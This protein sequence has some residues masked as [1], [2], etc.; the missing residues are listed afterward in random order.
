MDRLEHQAE[1]LKDILY[2]VVN[3]IPYAVWLKDTND[4]YILINKEYENF[5]GIK[6][7]DIVNKDVMSTLVEKGLTFDGTVDSLA[8][9]DKSVLKDKKVIE[10]EILMNVRNESRYVRIT[11]MPVC[12]KNGEVVALLGVSRDVTQQKLEEEK[13]QKRAVEEIQLAKEIQLSSLPQV[14]PPFPDQAVF[15]IYATMKPAKQV[16][17]DFY[18]FFYVNKDTVAFTVADVSDKGIPAALF[19]M[20]TKAILQS[21]AQ[22]TQ[23]IENIMTNVNNQICANN[24]KWFFVTVGL[25]II[26]LKTGELT[27][28]NAGHTQPIIKTK[29]G[30]KYITPPTNIALG[31][32]EGM[33]FEVVKMKLNPG[34]IM[35]LYTDGVTDAVNNENELYGS[36]RL[37]QL[38]EQN[39]ADPRVIVDSI[40]NEILDFAGEEEQADDLTMLAFSYMGTENYVNKIFVP[41]QI[42][43]LNDFYAWLEECCNNCIISSDKKSKIF[44]AAEEIFSNIVNYAYS[45]NAQN[46]E[47]TT[48][49]FKYIKPT[50]EIM[51]VF[52]DSGIRY[53]PLE[54]EEP[55]IDGS[56]DDKNPGG[57]GIMMVKKMADDVK[58]DYAYNRNILILTFRDLF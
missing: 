36:D 8:N 7:E 48:I 38:V 41:A 17:G 33:Q 28:I 44:I 37:L 49:Y 35:F 47:E 21:S 6:N 14:F 19:M 56:I 23:V 40:S 1:H 31:I 54:T 50:N 18:D 13:R 4:S 11:K 34:D 3:S 58:Y 30:A 22:T 16:G 42:S 55:N 20:K 12:D 15:D 5:Y 9:V 24:E 29:D 32:F 25:G 45:E 46:K 10:Q 27:Y 26:D 52:S 57:L 2:A 51:L 39:I 53:N 43:K